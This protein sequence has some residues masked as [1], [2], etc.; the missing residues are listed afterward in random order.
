MR[1]KQRG[2]MRSKLTRLRPI[3]ILACL[4]VLHSPIGL[5]AEPEIRTAKQVAVECGLT[6]S[7]LTQVPPELYDCIRHYANTGTKYFAK[8]LRDEG[9]VTG[10]KDRLAAMQRKAT[11][12][13]A[14]NYTLSTQ[15]RYVLLRDASGMYHT[16]KFATLQTY[17]VATSKKGVSADSQV[18]S[19]YT[20]QTQSPGDF[21]RSFLSRG[22]DG[23]IYLH[24]EMCTVRKDGEDP[25]L[26]AERFVLEELEGSWEGYLRG[27][28]TLLRLN[29]VEAEK[30]QKAQAKFTAAEAGDGREDADEG[31]VKALREAAELGA[32]TKAKVDVESKELGAGAALLYVKRDAML[33]IDSAK[34]LSFTSVTEK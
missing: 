12:R 34:S 20:R 26:Y 18:N 23:T 25:T 24:E 4:V 13:F 27:D 28:I 29:N 2:Q 31:V 11:K 7:D 8:E 21:D 6:D 16:V 3:A 10:L 19:L 17:V 33:W 9:D 14:A 30:R 15:P 1:Q 5:A 22:D 32:E